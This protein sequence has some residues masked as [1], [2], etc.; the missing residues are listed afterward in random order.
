[1]IQML[2]H[3]TWMEQKKRTR[4][5]DGVWAKKRSLRGESDVFGKRNETGLCLTTRSSVIM[6]V[7]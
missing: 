1:M 7:R 5:S 2:A 3:M 6:G 4:K